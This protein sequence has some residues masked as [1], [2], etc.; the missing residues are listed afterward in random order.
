[1]GMFTKSWSC[2][3]VNITIGSALA[4]WGPALEM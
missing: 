2:E 4:H 1:M 3:L